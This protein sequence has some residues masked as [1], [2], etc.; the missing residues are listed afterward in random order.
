MRR[1]LWPN[2]RPK[3][4]YN[5]LNTLKNYHLLSRARVPV[6][7]MATWGLAGEHVYSL[8]V[9]AW[10]HTASAEPDVTYLVHGEPD[11]S[12]GLADRIAR[13]GWDA[14]IPRLGERVR[15]D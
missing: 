10:L 1:L 4:T 8:G 3:T 5:R 7:E 13:S 6:Q 11:A 9:G 14:V 12:L 2:G 15:L